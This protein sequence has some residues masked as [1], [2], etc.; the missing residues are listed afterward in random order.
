MCS[1]DE[2]LN[3]EIAHGNEF[4]L[5]LEDK[6][7]AMPATETTEGPRYCPV[8]N[9]KYLRGANCADDGAQLIRG[10]PPARSSPTPHHLPK[11]LPPPPQERHWGMWGGIAAGVVAIAV[12]AGLFL[13]QRAAK[14]QATALAA[15]QAAA[16]AEAARIAAL[17]PPVQ[18]VSD[19]EI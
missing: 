10:S 6:E 15:Q 5:D 12:A 1:E 3:A 14:E 2:A 17:P 16:A 13:Y 18:G 11:T 19:T 8:C 4:D 9:R 7:F